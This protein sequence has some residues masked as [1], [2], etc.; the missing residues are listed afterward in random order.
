M[1][2]EGPVLQSY[3]HHLEKKARSTTLHS[4]IH[5]THGLLSYDA[6]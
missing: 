5:N 3:L 6:G 1:N 4:D 2:S